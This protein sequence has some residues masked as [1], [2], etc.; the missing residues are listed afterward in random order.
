MVNPSPS[1]P[2][3]AVLRAERR[4][5]GL[6]QEALAQR[7]GRT[8]YQTIWQWENEINSPQLTN[9]RAWAEALGYAVVLS[10]ID[11]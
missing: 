3:L 2:I 9:L 10:R 5:Q 7:L 6:S 4:R 1:D 11:G 8:T